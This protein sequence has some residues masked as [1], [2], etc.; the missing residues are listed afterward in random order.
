[1]AHDRAI[2]RKSAVVERQPLASTIAGHANCPQTSPA[3][4]LRQR[5]GNQGMQALI[6]RAVTQPL[7]PV[8][9]LP[10]SPSTVQRAANV[11]SPHDPAELEAEATARKVMRMAVPDSAGV[12]VEGTSQSQVQRVSGPTV[13]S[14]PPM[15]AVQSHTGGGAPLA[16]PVRGFMEPRFGAD[17]SSVRIHTGES[18]ARLSTNL[19]AHAFTVGQHIFFGKNKYQPDTQTG[20]ELI[21]HELTHT[22]QQGGA[23]ASTA[24][25]SAHSEVGQ[26]GRLWESISPLAQAA[27]VQ[28]APG[29]ELLTA[30]NEALSKS[31][32]NEVA[33]RLNGFNDADIKGLVST[34]SRATLTAVKDAA[35]EVMPGWNARVVRPVNARLAAR[36]GSEKSLYAS[37]K[38]I[39][40]YLL[41]SPFL[42][43]YVSSKFSGGNPLEGHIHIPDDAAFRTAC[44]AYIM[45]Q[46]KTRAEAEAAEPQVGAFRQG[47]DIYVRESGGTFATT[48][49]ESMHLFSSP[50]Y[51]R[52]LSNNANE[53]AA[54]YF[55]RIICRDQGLTRTGVYESQFRCTELLV[56]ATSKVTVADAYFSGALTALATAVDTAKSAGTLNR[57]S[58]FMNAGLYTQAD[59]L[60][61]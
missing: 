37:A 46:G 50:A 40:D 16:P 55:T 17:F 42:K 19:D 43:T 14:G 26:P 49:H 10:V 53:G 60:L 61:K 3:N 23:A 33:V 25:A 36:M 7:E 57:W 47:D 12:R 15:G 27:F 48:I 30:Y 9:T 24:T 4:T 13:H 28:C 51:Q 38:E 20:K 31:D 21:A 1:M 41:H 59:A 32:W 5:L 6:A 22:I 39:K 8:P 58:T 52:H 45:G 54:E 29:Q 18:A 34:Y 2:N 11:S 44:I 56:G 35:L